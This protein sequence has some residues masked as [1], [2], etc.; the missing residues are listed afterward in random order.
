MLKNRKEGWEQRLITHIEKVHNKPFK[1]GQHD[2]ALFVCNC[3]YEMT[4]CDLAEDFRGKYKT[5]KEAFKM[6]RE[7]GC[8]NLRDIAFARTGTPYE[9][10]NFAK[11]GDVVL[12]KCGEGFSLGIVDMSGRFAVT[13]GENELVY[14][15]KDEWLEVWEI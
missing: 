7:K 4:G 5:K 3:I 1:R 14:K 13:T 10:I 9:N 12:L 15:P 2:C 8:E 6:L 11:R